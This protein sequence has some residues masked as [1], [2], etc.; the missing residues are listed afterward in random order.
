MNEEKEPKEKIESIE[1]GKMKTDSKKSSVGVIIIMAILLG[2]VIFLPTITDL[3]SNLKNPTNEIKPTNP[4]PIVDDEEP[5]KE[6]TEVYTEINVESFNFNGLKL[7]SLAL[8]FT[9]DYYFN[10]TIEN[11]LDEKIDFNKDNYYIELYTEEH[12]LLERIKIIGIELLSK[13]RNQYQLQINN[14]TFNAAKLF[15]IKEIET[16]NYPL[17]DLKNNSLTC[18]NKEVKIVYTFEEEKLTNIEHTVNYSNSDDLEL[19]SK[20]LTMYKEKSN[21]YINRP[22]FTS[23]VV[24]SGVKFIFNTKIDMNLASMNNINEPL[25]FSKSISPKIVNF[26]LESMRYN[27]S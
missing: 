11:T 23:S 17:I 22:G 15:V 20:K 2:T 5:Q 25:Y 4:K 1:L 16:D 24:E 21:N 10:V 27:C 14:N 8:T 13:A 6:E 19:Y 18:I 7:T 26:E 9:D 3:I 12:T